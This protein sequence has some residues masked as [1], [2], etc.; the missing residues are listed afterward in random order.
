MMNTNT[1]SLELNVE[2]FETGIADLLLKNGLVKLEE[3]KSGVYWVRFFLDFKDLIFDNGEYK[4]NKDIEKHRNKILKVFDNYSGEAIKEIQ[5]ENDKYS[6][7]FGFFY[8]L[9]NDY[10]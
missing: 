5:F 4:L 9:R 10:K 6:F 2:D 7:L 8:V 3:E 1:N